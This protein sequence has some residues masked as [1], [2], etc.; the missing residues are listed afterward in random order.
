MGGITNVGSKGS[1]GPSP[2]ASNH[3]RKEPLSSSPS[4]LSSSN[5]HLS[6]QSGVLRDPLIDVGGR[7]VVY[8]DSSCFEVTF[9]D[10]IPNPARPLDEGCEVLLSFLFDYLMT[11]H[12]FVRDNRSS[13]SNSTSNGP[14]P[15]P[16]GVSV[17]KLPATT[18]VPLS[19]SSIGTAS[20]PLIPTLEQAHMTT[21]NIAS[22][23]NSDKKTKAEVGNISFVLPAGTSPVLRSLWGQLELLSHGEM[24][25]REL[26]NFAGTSVASTTPG[27][28]G[29]SA[30][31]SNS[32]PSKDR[33]KIELHR[34]GRAWEMSRCSKSFHISDKNFM[35]ICD[36]IL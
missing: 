1:I 34:R 21:T 9:G 13:S 7:I 10:S 23:T 17:N 6:N 3:S 15:S 28:H 12:I 18:P 35:D 36:K 22:S 20:I 26:L 24:F 31:S 25:R 16:G 2:V 30:L 29:I 27:G 11:G 5:L 19:S 32:L 4:S 33:E 14:S 8:G